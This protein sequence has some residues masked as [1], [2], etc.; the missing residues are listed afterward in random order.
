MNQKD[1]RERDEE[2]KVRVREWGKE[3]EKTWNGLVTN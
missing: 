2:W 1:E 3:K